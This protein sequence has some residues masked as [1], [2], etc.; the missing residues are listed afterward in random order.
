MHFRKFP[1]AVM[2][3]VL[4]ITVICPQNIY[5]MTIHQED[6][7][8]H[9][10]MEAVLSHFSLIKD[11]LIT[12]YVNH[13]GQRIISHMPPQPFHYRF[14][15]I[16]EDTY[17]AF[18][19]PG[20]VIFLHSGLFEI[21][22]NEDELAGILAHEI[23][24][25]AHRHISERIEKSKTIGLVSLAGIAAAILAG[26]GGIGA[27]AEAL[28][29]GS[30]AAGQSLSL[31]YSREDEMEADKTGYRYLANAGYSGKGLLT[32][33]KKMREKEWYGS[34]EIPTYL[35]THPATEERITYLG[36][37]VT[38]EMEKTPLVKK[39]PSKEFQYAHTKLL[40]LYGSKDVMLDRFKKAVD[41]TPDSALAHYGYGLILERTASLKD[42]IEQLRIALGKEAFN[43]DMLIDLGRVY[44]MNG[45]YEDAFK[46]L[47]SAVSISPKNPEGRL[48][49]GRTQTALGKF[50]DAVAIL[51]S[52]PERNDLYPEVYYYLGEAYGKQE[53]M[54]KSHF[55]LGLY[56][57]KTKDLKNAEFHF[58]RALQLTKNPEEKQEIRRILE[59]IR[60]KIQHQRRQQTMG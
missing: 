27:A 1:M 34:N 7:L 33:L 8:S 51:G 40:A 53:N 5:P 25:V 20:G 26:V 41:N 14:Y 22:D 12:D 9:E 24:H 52:I 45:Q 58:N 50:D 39:E 54:A 15:V 19:G 6:Q 35:M 56:Y 10:Y 23:S 4:I 48:Y 2:A 44:F 57:H 3:V 29:V 36:T 38:E 17:N 49:L 37:R 47:K 30:V 59:D 18:A 42:S 60:Q 46:V 31:A 28:T 16:K 11:P 55:N 32:M 21:M 13:V 43:P